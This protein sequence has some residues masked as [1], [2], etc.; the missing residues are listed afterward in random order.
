MLRAD[1]REPVVVLDVDDQRLAAD[2]ERL[3]HRRGRLGLRRRRASSFSTTTT[4]SRRR[5]SAASAA[6]SAPSFTFAAAR[7]VAARLRAEHRAALAPQ[8]VADLA[9]A[10]AAGA[11]LPPRLLAGAADRG[12]V[13]GLVRAAALLPRSR[14]RPTPR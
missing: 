4:A 7:V 2:A 12:A 8:R 1:Q 11:L 13:L 10:G 14:A 9:D 6:R 3:E 5:A